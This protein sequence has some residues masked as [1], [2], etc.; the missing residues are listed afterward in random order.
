MKCPASMRGEVQEKVFG[1]LAS[2]GL[3]E[4]ANPLLMITRP[5]YGTYLLIGCG[6]K[7]INRRYACRSCKADIGVCPLCNAR[8][9]LKRPLKNYERFSCPTCK[10]ESFFSVA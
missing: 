6:L 4:L 9:S 7:S 3:K 1:G 10:K 8:W 2:E 5:L